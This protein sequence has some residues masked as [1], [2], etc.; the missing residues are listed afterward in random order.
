MKGLYIYREIKMENKIKIDIKSGL[1]K[2]P[3]AMQT[4]QGQSGV[5]VI[6]KS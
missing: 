1:R 4:V 5:N 2:N 6:K 3:V